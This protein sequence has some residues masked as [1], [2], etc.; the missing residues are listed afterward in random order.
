M[1]NPQP[2]Y[3][4]GY[5]PDLADVR[6]WLYSAPSGAPPAL[7][8]KIDLR[9]KTYP[10]PTYNQGPPNSCTGNAVAAMVGFVDRKQGGANINPSRRQIY[11]DARAIDGLETID[12]GAYIRS[13]LQAVANRGAAPEELFPYDVERI[14]EQPPQNV[15]D[16]ALLKQALA[17]LRVDINPDAM[18][19]CLAEG[20]PFV[21]GTTLYENYYEAASTGMVPMPAGSTVGG[22]AQ[23]FVGYS[24]IDRRFIVQ[25]SWG[26]FGANGF[27]FMPYDYAASENYSADCWTLHSL[28]EAEVP[29]PVKPV[30]TRVKVKKAG[31]KIIVFGRWAEGAHLRLDTATFPNA[32]EGDGQ[33]IATGL[34]LARGPHTAV[35]V[36]TTVA[37]EPFNFTI[38]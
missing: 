22:H 18:R 27:V 32:V 6:D 2:Q 5:L 14:N 33:I 15:Y 16:A 36:A 19:A 20:F 29:P 34:T 17:Y 25:G 8:A 38:E 35:V 9:P 23:M 30:I 13:A 4:L 10:V 26:S 3:G 28:E 7:P 31:R 1:T 37:S 24:D 11:Y 21:L 12:R